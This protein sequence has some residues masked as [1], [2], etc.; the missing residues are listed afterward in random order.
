MSGA[1]APSSKQ[2]LE[3]I[4]THIIVGKVQS[5]Y[6]YKERAGIPLVNGYEYDNKIAD[7][8][9]DKVEKGKIS[10]KLI[11]VRYWSR[12]WKGIGLQPPGA[13][14]YYPHPKKDQL[15]RFYLAKNSYVGLSEKENQDGGYNVVYV[16]G[17][18]PIKK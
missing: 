17:V 13:Q 7:V 1:K 8:K 15:C 16:N 11:Y 18:Q 14:S 12:T 10:E 6:S 2:Q 3:S 4:A 5:V 9:I